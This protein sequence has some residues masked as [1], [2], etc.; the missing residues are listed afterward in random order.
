MQTAQEVRRT[1]TDEALSWFDRLKRHYIGRV[2][3][4]YAIVIG[5]VMQVAAHV[6]PYFGWSGAVLPLVIVLLVSLPVVLVLTWLLARPRDA[7][8]SSAWQ[9]QHRKLGTAVSVL[10]VVLTAVSGFYAWQ[11]SELH[12]QRL[13]QVAAAPVPAKSIAALPFENLTADKNNE[14]F[15]AGM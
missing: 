14:Y 13:E 7:S 4:P 6:F 1:V 11:F 5:F 10:V 12:A 2:V 9:H 8:G 15:V 3:I